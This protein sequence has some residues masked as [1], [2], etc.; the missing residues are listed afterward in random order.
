MPVVPHCSVTGIGNG[1][2]V[3]LPDIVHVELEAQVD[4][5]DH[6][7]RRSSRPSEPPRGR[8]HT[9]IERGNVEAIEH[10][11]ERLHLIMAQIGNDAAERR[12]HSGKPWHQ[13]DFAGQSP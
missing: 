13:R 11:I 2:G 3:G 7:R 6:A 8:D 10:K 5:L 12:R 9:A 4:L 1:D